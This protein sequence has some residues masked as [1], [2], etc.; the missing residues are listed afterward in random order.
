ME[1]PALRG[2]VL[3]GGRSSRL[4]G[5]HKPAIEV[6]GE[7]IVARVVRALRAIDAEPVVVGDPAGVPAGVAVVREEPPFAG[8]LAAIAAGL[9]A[10]PPA[11]GVVL[12][13]G[14][15]MP[16][17]TPDALRRLASAAPGAVALAVDPSGRDQ[18]LCAAWDERVL[19][20]RAAAVG[21]PRDRPLRALLE[22]V[23]DAIRIPLPAAELADVDTPEDLRR[24]GAGDQTPGS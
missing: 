13:L 3:A 19:R 5:R 17:V 23:G 7:P 11:D 22:T 9:G 21:D 16:F 4:G 6:G 15:D 20:A 18:P 2:I 12:V 14:G 24:L 1:A 8:P 10:L